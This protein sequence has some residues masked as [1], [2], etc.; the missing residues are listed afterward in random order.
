MSYIRCPKCNQSTSIYHNSARF[1]RSI[2]EP[3]E[4]CSKCKTL[5]L[6]DF[7]NEWDLKSFESKIVY[8]LW[9]L[10]PICVFGTVSGTIAYFATKNS[11]VSVIG[12]MIGA[13]IPLFI[14]IANVAESKK[15]LLNEDYKRDLG[16]EGLI[17]EDFSESHKYLHL[18][19][20]LIPYG[21]IM[22][23]VIIILLSLS[24]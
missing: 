6:L 14:F 22:L 19:W 11:L 21:I 7:Q 16:G 5:I 15:R 3:F 24:M 13:I 17:Y 10:Y 9:L 12:L 20:I 4:K 1:S 18:L 23:F 8:V 2:G